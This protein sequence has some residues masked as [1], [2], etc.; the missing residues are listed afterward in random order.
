MG[1][2]LALG[3]SPLLFCI[4][5]G[6]TSAGCF[7]GVLF[8]WFLP[9]LGQQEASAGNW[10][11]RGERSRHFSVF[12]PQVAPLTAVSSVQLLQLQSDKP[13]LCG[14]G[15]RK[16]DCWVPSPT[17]QPQLLGCFSSVLS[18]PRDVRGLLLWDSGMWYHLFG[19]SPVSSSM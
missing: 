4:S 12:L 11:T 8:S 17:Q 5:G 16:G 1:G 9:G 2:E 7:R 6:L 18:S 3:P 13:S 14:F 15:C 10:R 19:F